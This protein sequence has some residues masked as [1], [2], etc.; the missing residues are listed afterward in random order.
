MTPTRSAQHLSLAG[1]GKQLQDV[2]EGVDPHVAIVALKRAQAEAKAAAEE[3]ALALRKT[4]ARRGGRD[5]PLHD[6]PFVF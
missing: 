5:E 2:Y 6:R 4:Q 1:S 3:R